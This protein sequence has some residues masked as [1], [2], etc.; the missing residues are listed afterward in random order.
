LDKKKSAISLKGRKV[1][2]FLARFKVFMLD[3]FDKSVWKIIRCK[4]GKER[5]LARRT[6]DILSDSY[7][8]VTTGKDHGCSGEKG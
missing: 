2:P 1:R 4:R 3:L 7:D 5:D 6:E 8:L